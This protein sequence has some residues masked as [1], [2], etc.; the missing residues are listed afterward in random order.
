MTAA[1]GK[2]AV[3]NA[4]QHSTYDV[5]MC[6]KFVRAEAWEIGS[7]YGSAIDAWNGAHKKHPGDRNPPDGAPC[8][9]RGGT[10]GH[11]VV[12]RR[13]DAGRIRSTDCTYSGKVSDA[14]LSWPETAW[15]D[16][17]LG[18]TEDLNGV[19]LPLGDPEPKPEEEMPKF[20]RTRL[21][22]PLQLKAGEWTTI[23]WDHVSSG[24]AGQAGQAAIMIGPSAYTATFLGTVSATGEVVRTRFLER[25]KNDKGDWETVDTYPNVEHL[26][27]SGST[28]IS[29]TRTQNVAK[30]DRLVCQVNIPNGGTLESAELDAL[31]F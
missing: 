13:H 4:D 23:T 31:Y 22:K 24:D 2:A 11:I 9:Y 30:G 19:D 8:F 7:L 6:L 18:W 15:G 29:D 17:Y 14:D 1:S 10:Y 3:A 12:Y 26:I 21:T 28:Y 25:R 20:S 5:G 27:T 16:D